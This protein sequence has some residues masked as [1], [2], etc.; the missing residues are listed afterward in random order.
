MWLFACATERETH[1]TSWLNPYI[2][3]FY[4]PKFSQNIKSKSLIDSKIEKI[5]ISSRL[6]ITTSFK[7]FGFIIQICAIFLWFIQK[8][9]RKIVWKWVIVACF[10]IRKACFCS[11]AFN[12]TSFNVFW[13]PFVPNRCKMCQFRVIFCHF[14]NKYK[15][16]DFA[17]QTQWAR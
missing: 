16:K 15:K 2:F 10:I 5:V 8:S 12:M 11:C 6:F 7:T 4:I 9:C 17:H 1:F 3:Q 13:K 14:V